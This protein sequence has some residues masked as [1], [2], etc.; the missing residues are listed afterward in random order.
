MEKNLPAAA[1]FGAMPL[2]EMNAEA[3]TPDYFIRHYKEILVMYIANGR[4][5]KDTLTGHYSHIGQFIAWCAEQGL[6]PLAAREY[7]LRIYLAWLNG[8]GYKKD[9]AA[10]KIVALRAFFN[11]AQKLGLINENPCRDIHIGTTFHA[12]TAANFFTP[13]QLFTINSAL[14]D[15]KN[16]FLRCRGRAIIF[17]MGVEGLRNVEVHRMNRE[18]VDWEIGS[19]YIH[20]KGHDRQIFPCGE[21]IRT[22]KEYLDAAPPPKKNGG[23]TTPMFLSDSNHNVGGRLSRNGIRFIIDNALKKA[24]LKKKGISCHVFRHSCGTNLYAAEKDLRLVQ[25]VLG[26]RDPKTTARYSHVHDRMTKRS[27][28]AIVPKRKNDDA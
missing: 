4:P 10:M 15:E 17:L 14:D 28:G 2:V 27:T 8:Q 13:E 12:D 5:A 9:S 20:G 26:H 21:T 1:D 3:I 23:M 6:H 24:G 18:D 22:L 19:I 25:E 7:H 16:D 11:A